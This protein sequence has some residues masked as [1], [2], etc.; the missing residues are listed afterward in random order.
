MF[1]QSEF[2]TDEE[3]FAGG[4][5]IDYVGLVD[6][7]PKALCEAKS[8]SVMKKVSSS[9][10]PRG[11]ELKWVR[12][13]ALAPNILAKVSTLFPVDYIISLWSICR[14]HCIWV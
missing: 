7:E 6:N 1:D 5:K 11:I 3:H 14:P 10:P 12:G 13:Q 9:L 4:S 2:G 8:P